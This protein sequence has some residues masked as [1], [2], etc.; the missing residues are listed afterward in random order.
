MCA[1][2]GVKLFSMLSHKQLQMAFLSVLLYKASPM[3]ESSACLTCETLTIP[4]SRKLI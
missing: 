3:L 1:L 4:F 2:N